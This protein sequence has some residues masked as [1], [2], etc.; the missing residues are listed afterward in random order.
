[1]KDPTR[2][3]A[4]FSLKRC[5]LHIPVGLI[6]GLSLVYLLALGWAIVLVFALYEITEDWRIRDHAYID[7]IGFLLG[8]CAVA[9]VLLPENVSWSVF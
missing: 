7:I 2:L 5:A 6:A 3:P 9:L 8:L 4:V 1:M